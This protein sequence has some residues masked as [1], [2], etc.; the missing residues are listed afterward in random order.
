MPPV[1]YERPVMPGGGMQMVQQAPPLAVMKKDK[2]GLVKTIV[3]IILSL[4]TVTFIG[5][6]VWMSM[7]YSEAQR[8]VNEKITKAVADAKDEQAEQ[9]RIKQENDEK[10]PYRTFVGPA[11]YGQLS[12]EYPKTWSVYIE[13]DA[14]N[15][16]DF[17]AYLN[18]IEVNVVSKDTINALRVSIVGD[19]YESVV[20][21]Y[22]KEVDK[23][24]SQLSVESITIGNVEKGTQVVANKYSGNIPGTELNG[25][26]VVFKIRDKTVIMQTDSQLFGGEFDKLLGTVIFNA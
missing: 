20:N 26:I 10:Y 5:L 2:S 25:Y 6:F 3:I 23:K 14:S 16:G 9:D 12:F 22:Q 11:D 13:A 15:G 17:K 19:S 24:D 18:P 8:D 4:V 1:Q 21:K 7:Q